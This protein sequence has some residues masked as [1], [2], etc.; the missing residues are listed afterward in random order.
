MTNAGV[1]PRVADTQTVSDLAGAGQDTE[2]V[3]DPVWAGDPA[4]AGYS[5]EMVSD[6]I[7]GE[8][9]AGADSAGGGA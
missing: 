8:D 1:A 6:P 5:T 7:G 4:G 2:M 9:P 3:P